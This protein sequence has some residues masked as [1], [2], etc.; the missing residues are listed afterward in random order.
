MSLKTFRRSVITLTKRCNFALV[1]LMTSFSTFNVASRQ[2]HT[3]IANGFLLSNYGIHNRM[4]EM[5][6]LSPARMLHRTPTYRGGAAGNDKS[7]T[8][9]SNKSFYDFSVKSLQGD[10]II[11]MSEYKDK[12]V[13]LIVNV[14]SKWGVTSQNYKELQSLYEKYEAKG[15]VVL[16]FPCN[17]FGKQEP[18][19][20]SQLEKFLAK[21]GI[22]FPVFE[23]IEVNGENALPLFTYLKK[24]DIKWN[25]TKFLVI[26]GKVIERFETKESPFSFEKSI[27]DAL[28]NS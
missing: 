25:F 15:F 4:T 14:A 20:S 2:Y 22:T 10:K 5:R 28:V 13:I 19:T 17:Q 23:K 18:G 7:E 26:D 9:M 24:E 8:I 3:G 11:P 27:S 12:K 1:T 16:G 21:R 6:S